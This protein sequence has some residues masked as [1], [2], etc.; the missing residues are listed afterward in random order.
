MKAIFKDMVEHAIIA[1]HTGRNISSLPGVTLQQ[2]PYP[3]YIE[4]RFIIAI[5]RTFPLFM[6]LAWVYSASMIIKSI[7]HEKEM[8]L[9]ETMRVMGL[10]N[11]VHWISWFLDSFAVMFTSCVLLTIILVVS[12]ILIFQSV[13]LSMFYLSIILLAKDLVDQYLQFTWVL[14]GFC[15]FMQ[16]LYLD[17]QISASTFKLLLFHI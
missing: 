13:K 1:E 12:D 11:S 16:P 6:T 9:K 8:R 4:D 3:C 17:Q 5:A 2:M 10:G 14:W 7:V 15:W